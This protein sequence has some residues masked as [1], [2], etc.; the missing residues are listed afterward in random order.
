MLMRMF[1]LSLG[2]LVSPA[3]RRRVAGDVRMMAMW[4]LDR[5]RKTDWLLTAPFVVLVVAWLYFLGGWVFGY[6]EFA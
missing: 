4:N 5:P 1:W 2:L 3:V 6:M